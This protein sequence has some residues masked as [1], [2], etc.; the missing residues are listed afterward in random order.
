MTLD[1]DGRFAGLRV[2]G[3]SYEFVAKRINAGVLILSSDFPVALGND[4]VYFAP[5]AKA[6]SM[7]PQP[8]AAPWRGSIGAGPSRPCCAPKVPGLPRPWP[9][10]GM[11]STC[12]S[13]CTRP[14]T[15]DDSGSPA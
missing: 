9:C 5:Y 11:R 3:G 8:D 14:A 7:S 13:T 1:A 4:L 10:T 2:Q 12:S 15:I 6:P